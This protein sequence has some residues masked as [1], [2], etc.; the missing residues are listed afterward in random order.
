MNPQEFKNLVQNPFPLASLVVDVF[1]TVGNTLDQIRD[2]IVG[3][4]SKRDRSGR[5]HYSSKWIPGVH[6]LRRTG[7]FESIWEEDAR[8][9]E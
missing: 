3:Q 2:D 1:N 7:I 9:K 5:F 8:V 4:D 6:Q